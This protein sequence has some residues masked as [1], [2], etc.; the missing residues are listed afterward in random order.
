[1]TLAHEP[2]RQ[3]TRRDVLR[4]GLALAALGAV[5]PSGVAWADEPASAGEPIALGSRRE[6]FVDD[7]LI[8]TLVGAELKLH[9]PDSRDVALVCDRPWEGNTSAYYT[10]FR[11]EERFRM[12]YR[13]A[14]F[15]EKTKKSAHPEFSCFAESRDGLAWEKSE[16]GLFE[17]EGAKQNNI[18][19]AGKGT[20]NFT[21]F[22]DGNPACEPDARYK[23]L[24]GGS[25]LLN[26]KK[27]GC[28]N[29]LK[30]ADGIHW[31]SLSEAVITDGAFDSQNLAFWDSV[32]GEYRAYWRIFTTRPSAEP[33]RKATGYRAIRTATS[34]DFIHWERQADLEYENSPDEHLYTNA[35]QPYFRAPHLLIGFPTRFQPKTQQVE[36]VLMTSRDGTHFR[37]WSDALIPITAPKD[38]D[39]NRSNYMT[40]GLLQLPG[41]DRELSV[42]ATEAYYTGPGSRV[43]R[44]TFR[45][46]GF[47]SVRADA[48]GTV[49]TKSLLFAGSRLSLNI[50][51]QGRTRVEVQD[52]GGRPLPGLTLDDCSPITGD[53]I[54][55]EV[56]WKAGDLAALAGKPVRLRFV[57]EDADLFSMRFE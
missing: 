24:A 6:L 27:H 17:F 37:R 57:L 9:R 56:S 41:N 16:L 8:E 51:S 53:Q 28:L 2:A 38:R 23:A 48:E 12:Y 44:F 29:A 30:S 4:Q 35:V 26:G 11:D 14:H 25:T 43:R 54:E 39:G 42:Y 55:Q 52:P 31:S 5:K 50:A 20:H 22:K 49:V 47:V 40:W 32:R 34:K 36:P 3:I 15:D 10:L 19:W 33:G 1:M 46:D 21:P 18:V 7:F 13:G 45:T